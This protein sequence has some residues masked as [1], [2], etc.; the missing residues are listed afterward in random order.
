MPH[1]LPVWDSASKV[2]VMHWSAP[3]GQ[4]HSDR[5]GISGK[6]GGRG[7]E[8]DGQEVS[9]GQRRKA[10]RDGRRELYMEK[11]EKIRENG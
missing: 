8:R 11:I 3:A 10:E 9:E 5:G 6:E 1:P 4:G 2:V 7:R